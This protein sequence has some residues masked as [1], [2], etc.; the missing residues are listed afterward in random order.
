MITSIKSKE[1]FTHT[2]PL[3]H[4][5]FHTMKSMK[6]RKILFFLAFAQV[7]TNLFEKWRS[8]VY[9]RNLAASFSNSSSFVE[10]MA[11]KFPKTLIIFFL[12]ALW[13]CVINWLRCAGA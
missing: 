8:H 1:F 7:E 2:K 3:S 10:T 9:N 6:F 11:D 4:K 12:V 13:L 5:E